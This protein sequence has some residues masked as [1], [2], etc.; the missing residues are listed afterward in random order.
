MQAYLMGAAESLAVGFAIGVGSVW[1]TPDAVVLTKAGLI[2]AGSVGAKVAVIYFIAYLRKN[3]AFR[4]VWT[5][6]QRQAEA[7]K[8]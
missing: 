1:V 6:E 2:A 7:E 5:E 4:P 3:V 8:K